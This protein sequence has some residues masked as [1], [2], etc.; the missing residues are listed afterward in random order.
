M[1]RRLSRGIHFGIDSINGE[2]NVSS[3]RID[4]ALFLWIYTQIQNTKDYRICKICGNLFTVRSQKNRQFCYTH[5]EF[6]SDYFYKKRRKQRRK[7]QEQAACANA[8]DAG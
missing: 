3:D 6:A 7:A 2:T 1:Q 8:E 5:S 4:N